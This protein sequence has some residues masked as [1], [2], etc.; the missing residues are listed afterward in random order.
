MS[1]ARQF[2]IEVEAGINADLGA[3]LNDPEPSPA[4]QRVRELLRLQLQRREQP[5][6]ALL[7]QAVIELRRETGIPYRPYRELLR[8]DLGGVS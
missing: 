2:D 7:K 5:G 4:A 1:K 3:V 8:D 6:M